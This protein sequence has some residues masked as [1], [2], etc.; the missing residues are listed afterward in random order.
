MYQV[1]KMSKKQVKNKTK[2]VHIILDETGS[3]STC[4]A[5]TIS[6]FNEYINN[7]KRE[8][9]I[10]VTLTTFNSNKIDIVYKNKNVTNIV[11]LTNERYN[12][13]FTTPLYD[14]V[15]KTIREID[16]AKNKENLIVVIT[17]GE[18]NSSKEYTRQMIFEKIKEKEKLGWTFV[19]MGA[20]QDAWAEGYKIGA[21]QG[22]TMNFDT[23]NMRATFCALSNSTRTWAQSGKQTSN[24]FK[25]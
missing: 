19:F 18:E 5:A 4:K 14:A 13:D 12:P 1:N 3:M 23:K 22:N 17:D 9:N 25:K 11:E 2:N 15:G 8:K 21:L 24:F 7:L 20:N 10:N 16:D 6:G